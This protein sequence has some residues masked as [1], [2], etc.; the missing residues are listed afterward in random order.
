MIIYKAYQ[1]RLEY[2]DVKDNVWCSAY[3]EI[4]EFSIKLELDNGRRQ[5]MSVPWTGYFES[6][7]SLEVVLATED[8]GEDR[9][10][11]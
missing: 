1:D 3:D 7:N 10:I 8:M 6:L 4:W 5:S 9:I 2:S 11:L